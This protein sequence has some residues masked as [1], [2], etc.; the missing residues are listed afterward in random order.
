MFSLMMDRRCLIEISRTFDVQDR[1][2]DRKNKPLE[3]KRSCP[4]QSLPF[5]CSL[6]L[7]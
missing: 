4:D 1:I 7:L 5:F 3:E 6:S 2:K